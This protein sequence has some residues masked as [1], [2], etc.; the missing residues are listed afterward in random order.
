MMFL[1]EDEIMR[2]EK[3]YNTSDLL[4]FDVAFYNFMASGLKDFA[5]LTDTYPD[6]YQNFEAWKAHLI[7]LSEKF[8]Q[9][10]KTYYVGD[11]D[12]ILL[13]TCLTDLEKVLPHLWY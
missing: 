9:L 5:E 11:R 7:D 12:P 2:L 10:I 3:G 8:H 4:D 1:N 6:E 13:H